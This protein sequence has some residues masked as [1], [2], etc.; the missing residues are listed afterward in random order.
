[1]TAH[2]QFVPIPGLADAVRRE[3]DVRASAWVNSVQTIAGVQVRHMTLRDLTTL[4]AMRNGFCCPW[5]FDSVDEMLGHAAQLVW[6]LSGLPKPPLNSNRVWHPLVMAHRSRLMRHLAVRPAELINDTKRY[7]DNTFMDAPKGGGAVSGSPIAASPAYIADTLAAGGLFEGTDAM[8]D[9][10]LVRTWQLMRLASR[11][12]FG[13]PAT[14]ESDKLACD[15][16]A[17]LNQGN[18]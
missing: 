5:R 3:A 11:R 2:L 14:N 12:V 10:P 13:V 4:E 1:M 18:N 7:L 15:Y 6:W 17:R 9:A 8:L 16:L